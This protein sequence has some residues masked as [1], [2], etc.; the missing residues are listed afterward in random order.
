[1]ELSFGFTNYLENVNNAHKVFRNIGI[2]VVGIVFEQNQGFTVTMVH[3]LSRFD[4]IHGASFI[5]F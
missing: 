2:I 1:M 5:E 4:C 3:I